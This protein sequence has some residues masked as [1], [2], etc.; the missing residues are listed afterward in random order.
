MRTAFIEGSPFEN[1]ANTSS[2][3]L[4]EFPFWHQKISLCA[5]CHKGNE[6]L[7]RKVLTADRVWRALPVV[8]DTTCQVGEWHISH[9]GSTPPPSAVS[10]AIVCLTSAWY[11]ESMVLTGRVRSTF[12][13]TPIAPE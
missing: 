3:G 9:C 4:G 7:C 13:F 8:L 2:S 10:L 1:Q 12:W 5:G 11:R 6:L